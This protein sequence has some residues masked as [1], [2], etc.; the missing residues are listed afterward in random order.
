MRDFDPSTITD[1]INRFRKEFGNKYR[2]RRMTVSPDEYLGAIDSLIKSSS[3]IGT[4]SINIL[5]NI[6]S[7]D[8]K[9]SFFTIELI[10]VHLG[11]EIDFDL[12]CIIYCKEN[13]LFDEMGNATLDFGD[14]RVP[15]TNFAEHS[16][17]EG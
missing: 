16:V 10:P 14:V 2:V 13:M 15:I 1:D 4:D 5:R 9:V 11:V 8:S 17:Y 7:G 3:K 12:A 6:R